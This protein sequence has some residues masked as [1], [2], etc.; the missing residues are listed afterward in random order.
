MSITPQIPNNPSYQWLNNITVVDDR[1]GAVKPI[2]NRF[3]YVASMVI[4]LLNII[5]LILTTRFLSGLKNYYRN[6]KP[7][8]PDQWALQMIGRMSRC[9][10][11]ANST[12]LKIIII[13]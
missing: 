12:S 3:Y 5:L 8:I 9:G 6:I 1:T 7:S 13:N 11:L 4:Y 2:N 10:K